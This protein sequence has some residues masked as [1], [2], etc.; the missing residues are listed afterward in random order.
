MQAALAPQ[1]KRILV[2]PDGEFVPLMVP[3]DDVANWNV[4]QAL[5][6]MLGL[7]PKDVLRLKAHRVSVFVIP[8]EGYDDAQKGGTEEAL[9]TEAA[10][11]AVAVKL[12][13]SFNDLVLQLRKSSEADDNSYILGIV[14]ATPAAA[15]ERLAGR[16]AEL[17]CLCSFAAHR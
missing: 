11:A 3:W 7:N 5:V 16:L 2:S 6:E 12:T 8:S 9:L 10:A 1:P 4:A 14:I 13:G 17:V 15:S